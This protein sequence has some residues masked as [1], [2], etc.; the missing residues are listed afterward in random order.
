MF[1]YLKSP[2]SI[3]CFLVFGFWSV[4]QGQP[5]HGSKFEQLGPMLSSP[6]QYR[7]ADGAP[8]PDYW[9]Q[10]ADYII[11]CQLDV[12][13]QRLD[14]TELI[15]YHNNSPN[16]LKYLWLQLD[17]NQHAADANNQK[18]DPSSISPTMSEQELRA[19]EP[20]R[21]L[22]KFGV[23]IQEVVQKNGTPLE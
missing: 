4:A 3:I 1:N 6:N 2:I 12:D 8:G 18:F 21:E 14:G 17:E 11:D 16:T 13:N 5:N 22:D 15:T 23:N 9:Q 19:L 10:N 7:G 20:W